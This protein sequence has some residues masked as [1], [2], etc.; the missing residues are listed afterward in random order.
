M[1]VFEAAKWMVTHPGKEMVDSDGDVWWWDRR[2]VD[3]RIALPGG[4]YPGSLFRCQELTFEPKAK[5]RPI[6]P[7]TRIAKPF[8]ALSGHPCVKLPKRFRGKRVK[9][10]AE[11]C[12]G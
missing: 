9:I 4:N 1:D 6:A 10:R 3:F 11:V 8:T 12:D 2:R 7:H 5:S